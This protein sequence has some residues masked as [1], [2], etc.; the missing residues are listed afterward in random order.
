MDHFPW[1]L[2]PFPKVLVDFGPGGF[3]PLSR[4]SADY[5][6]PI[7]TDFWLIL[8]QEVL[9]H[10]PDVSPTTICRLAQIFGRRWSRRPPK[11]VA[12]RHDQKT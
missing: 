3:G 10:F 8:A 9:A 7:G 12:K 5:N 1:I 4:R 2:D 11:D 6:L